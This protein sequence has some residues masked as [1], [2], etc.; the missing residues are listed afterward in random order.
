[1]DAAAAVV[2][3]TPV[4]PALYF[5]YHLG[6]LVALGAVIGVP[7]YHLRPGVA[8]RVYPQQKQMVFWQQ[9]GPAG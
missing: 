3:P 5:H 7:G 9:D 8:S 2:C 4:V 1:V 6:V